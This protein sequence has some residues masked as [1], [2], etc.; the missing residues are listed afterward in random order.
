MLMTSN[1]HQ[2]QASLK[3]GTKICK[4]P[5]LIS[6]GPRQNYTAGT[7]DEGVLAFRTLYDVE[8]FVG[9]L[10]SGGN[11]G[12][13]QK[14]KK[15]MVQSADRVLSRARNRAMGVVHLLSGSTGGTKRVR[16][17]EWDS[18]TCVVGMTNQSTDDKSS[19]DDDEE[20]EE[21][22]AS[23]SLVDWLSEPLRKKTREDNDTGSVQ[24]LPMDS[25]PNINK[26]IN[27]Q[28]S[29]KDK[30]REPEV[31]KNDDED[32]NNVDIKD[33]FISL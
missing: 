2:Q 25:L 27:N 14:K 13:K 29:C 16:Q 24:N 30:G 26:S 12:N 4:F 11:N 28:I 10:L 1:Q 19:D 32:D 18:K 15:G 20:T 22:G 7:N 21:A 8:C 5:L 17:R 31:D 6:S 33:G 3:D 9:T 23:R